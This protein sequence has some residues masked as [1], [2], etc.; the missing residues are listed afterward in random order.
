MIRCGTT[1]F[2]D[3]GSYYMDAAA[4]VYEKSGLRGCLSVST[5]DEAG[6][7]E[8]ISMKCPAGGKGDRPAL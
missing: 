7:Q 3:A 8:S 1:S 5:M 4:E 2:V 6:L